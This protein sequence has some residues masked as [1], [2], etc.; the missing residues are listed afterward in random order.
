MLVFDVKERVSA[1]E[2]LAHLYLTQYHDP[3]DEPEVEQAFD[4]SFD[5]SDA[6]G[7]ARRLMVYVPYQHN[8]KSAH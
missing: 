6:I 5:S 2:A 7:D 3:A 4:W 1:K 8:I